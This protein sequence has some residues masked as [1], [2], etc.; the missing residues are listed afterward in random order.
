MTSSNVTNP[1]LIPP[2]TERLALNRFEPDE[3]NPHIEV[4]QA[5]A[6]ETGAGPLLER[7]CPAHVYSAGADGSIRV[8]YAACLECGTCSQVA[9]PGVLKWAYPQGGAGVVYREG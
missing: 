7:I 6:Q 4:D 2:I 8:L 3:G 1:Q 5:L 9:P